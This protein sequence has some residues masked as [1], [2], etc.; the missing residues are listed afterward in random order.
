MFSVRC[1]CIVL[2]ISFLTGC[3]AAASPASTAAPAFSPDGPEARGLALFSGKARCATCHSRTP[4]T[5]I[6]GPSLAGIAS[7]AGSREPG[8]SAADYIEESILQP[9]KFKVPGFENVQMDTS[10]AKILTSDEISD[11]VAYLMTLK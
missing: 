6:V 11:I 7:R 4:N 1:I 9:N 5:V 8:I 10:L 2:L 3:G